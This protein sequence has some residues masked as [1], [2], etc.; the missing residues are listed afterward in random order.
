VCKI[1]N[2]F[3]H[4]APVQEMLDRYRIAFLHEAHG[5]RPTVSQIGRRPAPRAGSEQRELPSGPASGCRPVS[6]PMRAI[7][8]RPSPSLGCKWFNSDRPAFTGR[9]RKTALTGHS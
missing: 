1:I 4:D 5:S 8:K 2:A 7:P 6:L 9:A 3:E